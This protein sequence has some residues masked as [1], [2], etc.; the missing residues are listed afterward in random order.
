MKALYLKD[1]AMFGVH[2]IM[3]PKEKQQIKKIALSKKIADGFVDYPLVD[4]KENNRINPQK[5]KG[6]WRN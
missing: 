3:K 4:Q 5:E 2:E 6:A 1:L